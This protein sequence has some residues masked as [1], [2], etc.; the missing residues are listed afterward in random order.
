M[1]PLLRPAGPT[2]PQVACAATVLLLASSTALVV[3]AA[4][5]MP[6]P[7]SWK[8]HSISES[9]AQGQLHAWLARLAFLCFGAAV[10]ILCLA[11]KRTWAKAAYWSH[12]AFALCMFTTAAFS[13][14]PWVPG[15]P[16]DEFEDLLHSLSATGMGFAF[17]AGVLARLLQRQPPATGARVR[18]AIALL[19]AT[20]LSPIGAAIPDI[21]GVLQRSM[22]LIAYV[23][24]G[25]EAV[26][27]VVRP[28]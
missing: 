10:L 2:I 11:R 4:V 19:A 16:F 26:E 18:D 25:S 17:A 8:F 12:L 6:V 13:H 20:V 9:A 21:A 28:K 3:L 24:Y 23:W 27:A 1:H 5:A 22:F 15:V 14:K 7:Y